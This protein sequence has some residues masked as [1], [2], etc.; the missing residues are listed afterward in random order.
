MA[1][2]RKSSLFLVASRKKFIEAVQFRF[3][4]LR[5]NRRLETFNRVEVERAP[6]L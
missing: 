6:G 2:G 1:A 5:V 4:V 3:R